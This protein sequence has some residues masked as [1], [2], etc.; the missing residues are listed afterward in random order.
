MDVVARHYSV[1]VA[2][3]CAVTR[4]KSAISARHTAMYIARVAGDF[5]YPEIGVA[6][7]R[8]HTTVMNAVSRVTRRLATDQLFRLSVER[9]TRDVLGKAPLGGWVSI[10]A[11]LLT[12]LQHKVTQKIYGASIEDVVDRILCAHF[13]QEA[14][15]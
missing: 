2:T 3:I 13:Q 12:R 11:E 14:A 6:F 1:P 9:L 5:S 8:D 10:R 7:Q 15:R 4:V